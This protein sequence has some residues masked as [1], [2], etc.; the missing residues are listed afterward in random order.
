[1]IPD[2]PARHRIKEQEDTVNAA[3]MWLKVVEADGIID[4]FQ[5]ARVSKRLNGR[6]RQL[7]GVALAALTE[8]RTDAVRGR[9]RISPDT[10][11]NVLR[12]MAFVQDFLDGFFPGIGG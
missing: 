6:Q 2:P 7:L 1:L 10:A 4:A 9:V 3:Q 11:V 8:A 5:N 12:C